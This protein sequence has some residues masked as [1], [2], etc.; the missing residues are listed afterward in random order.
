[1]KSNKRVVLASL[2]ACLL[3]GTSGIAL[4]QAAS[5]AQPKIVVGNQPGGATDIVARLLTPGFSTALGRQFLVDNRT[6]ASGNVAADHVAKSAPD[7]NTILL[8][9]NA[10]TTVGPLSTSLPFDPIRDFASVGMICE[11]PYLVVARPNIGVD[12]LRDLVA[13]A[14]RNKDTLSAGSPGQGTPQHLLFEKMM[15]DHGVTINTI[16]YKGSAPSQNDVMG[17]HVDFMLSTPSLGAPAV[18]AGKLA[19]LAVTSDARLADFPNTPTAREA[20]VESL[21]SANVWL[22]LLVPAKTPRATVAQLNRVLNDTLK[23]ADISGRL[24]AIGMAPAPGTP[25]AMD[26]VLREEQDVWAQLI[27]DAKIKVN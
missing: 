10:H 3:A 25:E 22:A 27:R 13:R 20:G 6:G 14:K 5:A 7:G 17:G 8:V 16:H 1:M 18:K 19:L 15:K 23:S 9:F 11:T 4:G 24:K 12:N 2:I 26:K 21:A